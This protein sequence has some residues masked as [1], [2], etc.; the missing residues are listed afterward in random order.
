MTFSRARRVLTRFAAITTFG[1]ALSGAAQAAN[2]LTAA[3][4]DV[5]NTFE[6]SYSVGT[7]AQT[8][9]NNNA[10]PTTFTVDRKVDMIL[11]ATNSVLTSPPGTTATLTYELLNEGNDAQ[12]YSFSIADLDNAGTTFDAGSVTIEYLVDTNDNGAIDVGATPANDG[13]F[14]VIAQTAIAAGS[15]TVT[16]DVPKGVRV[17]IRVTGTIASGIADASTDD[18]TLVAET[19]DPTAFANAGPVTP[20]AVTAATGGTNDLAVIENVL[21]DG[22]GVS[23]AETTGGDNTN[24]DGLYAATGVIRVESPD[25]AA[26][27][28][29]LTIKEPAAADPFVALTDCASATAVAN[30]KAIPGSCIEYVIEVTNS[31][32][33]ASAD[34]LVITDVL[35]AQ[36]TFIDASLTNTGGTGF[37]DN[38][39]TG[40]SGSLVLSEPAPSTACDGTDTTC[41]VEL[42]NASLGAGHTA[43]IRI[44]ALVK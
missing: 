24:P 38:L 21:A 23:A 11:T 36:V 1:L 31:G 16:G 15:G 13:T 26:T 4:T 28:T 32:A 40:A 44:R 27:K 8:P 7:V 41:E 20:G 30:A 10:S 14:A 43:Q 3:G 5:D 19:R 6:L 2:D 42:T 9:I 33:T 22:T 17:F 35:P 34:D 29:V 12:A 25:L 18:I 37:V 39:A